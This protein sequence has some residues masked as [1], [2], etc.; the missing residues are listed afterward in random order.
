MKSC[1]LVLLVERLRDPS[2]R[3]EEYLPPEIIM[4]H[5]GTFSLLGHGAI[6][7]FDEGSFHDQCDLPKR[8][9]N[10]RTDLHVM[11]INRSSKRTLLH[12]L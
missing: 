2:T 11:S 4:A 9:R 5:Y 12:S 1:E 8:H 10:N 3:I 7:K 6:L